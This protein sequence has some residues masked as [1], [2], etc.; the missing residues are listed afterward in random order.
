MVS[1]TTLDT[2]NVRTI[3]VLH[4]MIKYKQLWFLNLAWCASDVLVEE[5]KDNYCNSPSVP[6]Q[7]LKTT[8][9]PKFSSLPFCAILY[10]I[11]H[12]S[13]MVISSQV[14]V[15]IDTTQTLI[16]DVLQNGPQ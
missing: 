16:K 6:H 9:S 2:A 12:V 4:V 5:E 1:L 8:N 7:I 3:L 13:C 10:Y 15:N 11:S 14:T